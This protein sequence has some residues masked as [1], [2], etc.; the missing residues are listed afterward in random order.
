MPDAFSCRPNALGIDGPVTSASMMPVWWP[1]RLSSTASIEVT[2]DFPTPPLP[3]TTPTT[4]RTLLSSWGFSRKS[5]GFICLSAQFSPHDSQLCVHSLMQ[6][7]L[8]YRAPFENRPE[9][10]S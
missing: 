4:L 8:L 7:E 9:Y 3:L 1:R 2:R 10:H 5:S 6:S